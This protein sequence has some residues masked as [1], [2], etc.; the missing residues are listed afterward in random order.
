MRKKGRATAQNALIKHRLFRHAR[1]GLIP[2]YHLASW[3]EIEDHGHDG[4]VIRTDA[5]DVLETN[6][7]EKEISHPLPTTKPV[8]QPAR[9]SDLDP[10]P[11][12]TIKEMLEARSQL[13][14]V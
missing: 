1:L 5:S 10:L 6:H 4:F 8:R 13:S 2:G 7:R 14:A 3:P 11:T 12:G 9:Q